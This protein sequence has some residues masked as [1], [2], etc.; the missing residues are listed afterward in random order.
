MGMIHVRD[1][2]LSGDEHGKLSTGIPLVPKKVVDSYISGNDERLK[3]TILKFNTGDSSDLKE[4]ELK[5]PDQVV[6]AFIQENCVELSK[7]KWLCPLSGKK[8]KGPEFIRKH[9]FSKH[10]DKIESK[11]SEVINKL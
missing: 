3:A 11:K 4:V 2:Q 10:E 8:F 6:E 5:D 7:D 9:L 1:F